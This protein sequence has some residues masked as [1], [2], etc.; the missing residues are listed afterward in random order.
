MVLWNMRGNGAP[1]EE[2][3]QTHDRQKKQIVRKRDHMSE[4]KTAVSIVKH[5]KNKIIF[6][7]GKTI[8]KTEKS[9]DFKVFR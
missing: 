8:E 9:T 1:A 5:Q 7:L 3:S 6:F 2:K 4:G